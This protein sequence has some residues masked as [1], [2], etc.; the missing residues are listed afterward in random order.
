MYVAQRYIII[1]RFKNQGKNEKKP[2]IN[3]ENAI[4]ELQG[5]HIFCYFCLEY[6]L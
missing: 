4:Q 2:I 6:V 5:P 1:W 3:I